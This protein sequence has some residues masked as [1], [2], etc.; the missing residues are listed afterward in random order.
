[1]NGPSE[2]LFGSGRNKPS[3]RDA[4]R[5][6]AIA[7]KHGAVF[8]QATLPGTGYQHWFAA[9]N[10][11]EPFDSALARAISEELEAAGVAL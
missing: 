1:V 7:R 5:I 11:G 4:K 10:R 6:D 9:P 3:A 2:F 8:V